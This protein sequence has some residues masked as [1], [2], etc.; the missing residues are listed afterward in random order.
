[1]DEYNRQLYTMDQVDYYPLV[2]TGA[3]LVANS[4]NFGPLLVVEITADRDYSGKR[5]LWQP[6]QE[7]FL[8]KA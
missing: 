1:M 3:N 2:R 7:T 4:I 5:R 8:E 6:M